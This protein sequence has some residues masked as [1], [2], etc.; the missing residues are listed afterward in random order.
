MLATRTSS[1]PAEITPAQRR[2]E[3]ITILASGL[4]R[5]LRASRPRATGLIRICPMVAYEPLADC[6]WARLR[7][8]SDRS[9]GVP[10]PNTLLTR[11]TGSCNLW[12]RHA[13]TVINGCSV[14]FSRRC[15]PLILAAVSRMGPD[16]RGPQ[17]RRARMAR[18]GEHPASHLRRPAC[19]RA[20]AA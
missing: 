14:H 11:R 2:D 19:R 15:E 1:K 13:E 3:T 9:P 6:H 4:A 18:P 10:L 16:G 7:L 12:T 8:R 20:P 5:L 17:N